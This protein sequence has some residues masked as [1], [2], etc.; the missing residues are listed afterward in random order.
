MFVGAVLK[1][2]G[3]Y[4]TDKATDWSLE[5]NKDETEWGEGVAVECVQLLGDIYWGLKCMFSFKLKDGKT[6]F[7]ME[8]V[9]AKDLQ[10]YI[11]SGVTWHNHTFESSELQGHVDRYLGGDG[12][13]NS[14]DNDDDDGGGAQSNGGSDGDDIQDKDVERR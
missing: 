5:E 1:F 11:L 10:P 9:T 13:A 12:D 2:P 3:E 8:D 14:D 6:G 4:F 7:Y